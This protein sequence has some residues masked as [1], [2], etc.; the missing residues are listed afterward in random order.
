MR[1]LSRSIITSSDIGPLLIDINS[2][3]DPIPGKG[4]KGD[5]L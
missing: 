3:R 1:R 5:R 4:E 2:I